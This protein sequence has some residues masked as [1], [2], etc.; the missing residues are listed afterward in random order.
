MIIYYQRARLPMQMPSALCDATAA[1][2]SWQQRQ[3]VR[4]GAPRYSAFS[5]PFEL[6]YFGAIA[7][8]TDDTSRYYYLILSDDMAAGADAELGRLAY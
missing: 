3:L 8:A 5:S 4:H 6:R 1:A 2:A 7:N